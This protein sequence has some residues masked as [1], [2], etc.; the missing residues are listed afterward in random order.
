LLKAAEELLPFKKGL[1]ILLSLGGAFGCL[2]WINFYLDGSYFPLDVGGEIADANLPFR[3]RVSICPAVSV[4]LDFNYSVT[5]VT[6][7]YDRTEKTIGI[8]FLVNARAFLFAAGLL[9]FV[10]HNKLL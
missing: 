2:E 5:A 8:Q 7:L 10:L 9:G 6:F 4:R 3:R 1:E